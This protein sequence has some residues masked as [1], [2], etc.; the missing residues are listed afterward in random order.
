MKLLGLV[1]FVALMGLAFAPLMPQH[2]QPPAHFTAATMSWY[3][4][5]HHFVKLCKGDFAHCQMVVGPGFHKTVQ[6]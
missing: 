4:N 6:F 3:A 5:G 1:L 2:P